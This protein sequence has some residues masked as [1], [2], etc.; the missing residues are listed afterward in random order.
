MRPRDP[1]KADL[2]DLV[3]PL[4]VFIGQEVPEYCRKTSS[5]PAVAVAVRRALLEAREPVK[6]VFTA[7]PEACGFP[8][9]GKSGLKNPDEL[10]ARLRSAM[11]E[12]R[13]AY[14]KLIGRLRTALFAA[15]DIA[16]APPSGR[17]LIADRAAQLAVVVT[18]PTIKAFALRLADTAL[19]DRAWVESVA[20]FLARKSP[21]RWL[22][23]DE[24]EFHHQLGVVAGRFKR[25]EMALIG[26]TKRLNGHACRIA[27]T[28]SDGSEVGDLVDWDGMEEVRIVPLEGEIHQLLSKHGRYGL[29]AALRAIWTQ[30]ETRDKS[31][32]G[33][34]AKDK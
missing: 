26:T 16:P 19:D 4:A 22:D 13:T 33:D 12:I 5:M 25:T 20:N 23:A 3:R 2:L 8:P 9:I 18:E 7:L 21:E 29:A 24:A 32:Q 6:L 10:A 31:A 27:L 30:L 14:P 1:S 17:Q 28:K 11:H 34:H 15:F